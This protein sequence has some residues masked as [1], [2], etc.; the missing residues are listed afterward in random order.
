MLSHDDL[1]LNVY[2]HVPHGHKSNPSA[3]INQIWTDL[4]DYIG[5]YA[6]YSK[7]SNSFEL[8]SPLAQDDSN[9]QLAL[10]FVD[11]LIELSSTNLDAFKQHEFKLY[12]HGFQFQKTH[13]SDILICLNAL[14]YVKSPLIDINEKSTQDGF[15]PIN[16][17]SYICISIVDDKM[18]VNIS[19]DDTATMYETNDMK[20]HEIL[21]QL[22]SPKNKYRIQCTYGNSH[23]SVG[24]S[25]SEPI[26]IRSL[27]SRQGHGGIYNAWL[28]KMNNTSFV[29]PQVI[30]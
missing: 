19:F 2:S 23:S 10:K 17:S 27:K 28:V 29:L 5:S 14:T 25:P 20:F 30:I 3:Y 16:L 24:T 13:D 6:G 8:Y 15:T 1:V 26:I 12:I 11:G 7:D 21:R 9:P 22:Q 18:V 4:S